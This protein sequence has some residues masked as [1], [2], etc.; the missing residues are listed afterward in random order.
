[1]IWFLTDILQHEDGSAM[2]FDHM[3][4]ANNLFGEFRK[5][6]LEEV[7]CIFIKEQIRGPP[8]HLEGKVS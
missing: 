1:M 6:G 8:K 2:M 4:K 3:M 7:D 5:Y